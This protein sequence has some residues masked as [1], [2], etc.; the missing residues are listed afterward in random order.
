VPPMFNSQFPGVVV[1]FAAILVFFFLPWL[2]RSPVKSIRYK[3]ILF[4]LA[5]AIFVVTFVVLA[6][7]GMQASTPTKTLLAQIFT[8]LYFAFFLL[9]PFYS[10]IDKTKPVPERVTK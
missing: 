4:K 10:K 1:M 9:M 2:D 3:G 5:V 7:L 8:A 6:W